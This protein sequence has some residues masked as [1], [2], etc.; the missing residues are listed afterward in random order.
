VHFH[1]DLP[2]TVHVAEYP[3][4]CGMQ[5]PA[6]YCTIKV[7][8]TEHEL[9]LDAYRLGVAVISLGLSIVGFDGTSVQL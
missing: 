6:L 4:S 1:K 5:P 9:S 8:F 2:D 7:A 3:L